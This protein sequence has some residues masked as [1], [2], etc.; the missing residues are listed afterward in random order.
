MEWGA[1]LFQ[2]KSGV[3]TRVEWMIEWV[4]GR[5]SQVRGI[6]ECGLLVITG[7]GLLSGDYW[8]HGHVMVTLQ[9]SRADLQDLDERLD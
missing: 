6:K 5:K 3:P 4:E 1:G 7:W 2:C 9:Q 8:Y